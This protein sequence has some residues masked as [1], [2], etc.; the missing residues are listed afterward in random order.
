M[1]KHNTNPKRE[2]ERRAWASPGG[3][4]DLIKAELK[5][6]VILI[7][8]AQLRFPSALRRPDSGAR[9]SFLTV[10]LENIRPIWRCF[11]PSHAHMRFL[12]S[13]CSKKRKQSR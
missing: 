7:K 10:Y 1:I 3:N 5:S 13:V 11:H 6:I 2:R 8:D 4:A 12:M 9:F